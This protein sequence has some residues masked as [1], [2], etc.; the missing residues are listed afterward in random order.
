[1]GIEQRHEKRLDYIVWHQDIVTA[2]PTID[3]EIFLANHGAKREK[4]SKSVIYRWSRKRK[5][6]KVHQEIVT[7]TARDLEHFQIGDEHY[8]AVANH[9]R[10]KTR[11]FVRPSV[12]RQFEET[13]RITTTGAYDWTHFD[14]DGYHFMAVANSF[15]GPPARTTFI[16]SVVY[17]WQDGRFIP[18][19]TIETTG[20]TD[21]EFFRVHNE[22]FLVVAN[23]YN[24]GPQAAELAVD[25]EA[26]TVGSDHFLVVSNAQQNPKQDGVEPTNTRSVIYRWQGVEK[27]VPVHYLDTLPSADWECFH[28]GGSVFLVYANAK[29]TISQVYQVKLK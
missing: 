24:Y 20:A 22:F 29:G 1:M 9:V 3:I 11:F 16:K 25:W 12:G 4:P 17:F 23:A 13:Q 6:F 19:Q 5:L 28:V 27:F 2:A 21:W 14:L 10:G 7:W 8:I 15:S 26:F 18:F